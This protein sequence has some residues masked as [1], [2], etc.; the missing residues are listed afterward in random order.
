MEKA[1]HWGIIPAFALAAHTANQ[2]VAL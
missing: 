2:T 1:L